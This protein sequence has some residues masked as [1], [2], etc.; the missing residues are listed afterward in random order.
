MSN[1]N[2]LLTNINRTLIFPPSLSTEEIILFFNSKRSFR[3]HKDCHGY[4]LFRISVA[5]ECKRLDEDNKVIIT[6]AA[7]YL[8]KN[9]TRQEKFEYIN[10]AQRATLSFTLDNT[11]AFVVK[12]YGLTKVLNIGDLGPIDKQWKSPPELLCKKDY[13]TKSSVKVVQG[14][15][16]RLPTCKFFQSSLTKDKSDQKIQ[17]EGN[18]DDDNDDD[19]DDYDD[20]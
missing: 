19:D 6:C 18:D 5:R 13:T 10:L 12:C 14:I 8:W 3:S 16:T 20:D 9:S 1:L 2:D 15:K 7:N 11:S 4:M 17:T